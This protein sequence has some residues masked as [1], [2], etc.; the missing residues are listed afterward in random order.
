MSKKEFDR[1]HFNFAVPIDSIATDGNQQDAPR[2]FDGIAYSGAVIPR[3]FVFQNLYIDLDSIQAKSQIPIF[4]DHDASLVA[5]HGSLYKDQQNKLRVSGTLSKNAIGSDITQLAD[6]GFA[7]EMSI[8]AVPEY[9]EEV[10]PGKEVFINGETVSDGATIFR[11]TRIIETSFVPIGADSN[12]EVSVFSK[13][14]IDID[15]ETIT[16]EVRE[17]DNEIKP[18][19]A[20]EEVVAP[21]I[22]MKDTVAAETTEEVVVEEAQEITEEVVEA[23][24]EDLKLTV[25]RLT[26]ELACSCTEKKEA[27]SDLEKAQETIKELQS[28]IKELKSSKKKADFSFKAEQAGIKLSDDQ[29]DFFFAELSEDD[30]IDKVL[31]ILAEQKRNSKPAMPAEL[32]KNSQIEVNFGNKQDSQD[33]GDIAAQAKALQ[34]K[35][36]EKGES[37]EFSTAVA[38]VSNWS[39]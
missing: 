8:G 17:M 28:Q 34:A 5:G 13:D 14:G 12:T 19:E 6:E 35:L 1:D 25:E 37:I 29:V 24:E 36:A 7:W 4:R 26:A 18:V 20:A 10:Q 22:D 33:S 32:T 16:V 27:K 15:K 38:R 2:T 23:T 9:I 3:H 21:E 11:N 30:K 39:M 31:S